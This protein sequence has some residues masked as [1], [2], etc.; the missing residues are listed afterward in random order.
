MIAYYLS[1]RTIM[2]SWYVPAQFFS[3]IH[4]YYS[5]VA[6]LLRVLKEMPGSFDPSLVAAIDYA[7]AYLGSHESSLMTLRHSMNI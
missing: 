7:A 6:I 5:K 4:A 2:K 3:G 1:A